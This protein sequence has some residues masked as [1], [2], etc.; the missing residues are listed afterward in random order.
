MIEKYSKLEEF[1]LENNE[2]I[3]I[4]N[5]III[6][7][8]CYNYLFKTKKFEN[9]PIEFQVLVPVVLKKIFINVEENLKSDFIKE[10]VLKI[11]EKF[12]SFFNS[13]NS[14]CSNKKIN[15]E[16]EIVLLFSKK[17]S[18]KNYGNKNKR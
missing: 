4:E 2:K 13:I 16:E 18:F 3:N 17:Y 6:N 7:E 10:H 1:I 9:T 12:L 15:S 11:I 5:F 14:T 8:E